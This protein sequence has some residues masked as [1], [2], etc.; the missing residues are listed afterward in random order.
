MRRRV[1]KQGHNTLTV[2]L[3]SDW[4][5][6]HKISPGDELELDEKPQGLFLT[7]EKKLKENAR[8]DFDITD[9]D[10]PT[11]W[12]YFMA[13]YREGYDEVKVYFDSMKTL[14]FPYKFIT[15]HRTS[16]KATKQSK[17]FK[18]RSVTTSLQGFVDRFIGYEIVE[19]GKDYILI[20]DLGGIT[21]K[22]FDNSLR[23]VFL[24]IQQMAE[25]TLEA[26]TTGDTSLLDSIH[27]IDINLDKFHD[28][29][30]RVLNKIG[31]KD[32]EKKSLYFTTLY[33]IEM[34]G[35]EFKN[36]AIHLTQ[37]FSEGKFQNIIPLAKF[38]KEQIDAYYDLYYKFDKEKIKYISQVDQKTYIDV[39][40][41]YKKANEEEKEVFHHLRMIG[42]YI[43]SLL[44]LRIE[45]E[46]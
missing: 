25:E 32:P 6:K 39:P 13:V 11:I 12:K 18:K 27:D 38:V 4:T 37:D 41:L 10:I 20:K 16:P 17:E 1:I 35:D 15:H 8:A 33:L 22:E 44:E 34:M 36:I 42:R 14:D 7:T 3:P 40:K 43:N 24:L 30:I 21:S 2:T 5:K 26:L 29:C 28:Y 23:R 45:M 19:H 9:M 31:N 46:Y